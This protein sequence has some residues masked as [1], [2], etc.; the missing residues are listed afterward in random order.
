M[1]IKK[2]VHDSIVK[3][4]ELEQ[5]KLRGEIRS[6]KYKMN[7]LVGVQTRKKRELVELQKII[8][9]LAGR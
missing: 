1:N 9:S 7:N 8:N 4:L 3:K 2:A 5:S 6:N